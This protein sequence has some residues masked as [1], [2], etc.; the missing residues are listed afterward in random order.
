MLENLR[1]LVK[2]FV[3]LYWLNLMGVAV[4][5]FC[6]VQLFSMRSFEDALVPGVTALFGLVAMLAPD[7]VSDWTGHHGWTFQ[8][9]RSKP[10]SVI[11][12]SGISTLILTAIYLL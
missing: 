3:A 5:I 8:Q 7:E 12:Y 11:R 9:Y 1:D 10:P 6:L 2:G 4:F